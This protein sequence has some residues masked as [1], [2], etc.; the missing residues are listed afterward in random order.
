MALALSSSYTLFTNSEG[1]GCLSPQVCYEFNIHPS[2]P[3]AN[4]MK[5]I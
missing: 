4:N 2:T 5:D 1:F 3:I